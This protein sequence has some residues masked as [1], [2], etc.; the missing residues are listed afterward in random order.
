MV[1]AFLKSL[2]VLVSGML[3]IGCAVKK[4]QTILPE[5][6]PV[7]IQ[8]GKNEQKVDNF[9][10]ILD[11]SGTMN[12]TYN[13]QTKFQ[14]ASEVLKRMN[15]TIP[16]LKLTTGLRT[17][18]QGFSDTTKLQYGMTNYT[19]EGLE[20]AINSVNKGGATPLGLAINETGK[21]LENTQGN[22]AVII[23]SDGKETDGTSVKS[24]QSLKDK[25]RDRLC[26]YT[27]LVGDDLGGKALM[28]KIAKTGECGFSVN[29]DEI[30]SSGDIAGFV[31]K[32]F[33][34][35]AVAVAKPLDSDGDG[36]YDDSDRCPNTPAGVKVDA[37]GCPLDTDGDGVYDYMDKCPGTPT[38]VAVDSSGC[39]LDSDGDG[40]YDYLDKCPNTPR[41]VQVDAKGCPVDSDEDGVYDYMDKCPDTPKSAVVD[42][43]GCWV[44]KGVLFDTAK[45]DI[46]PQSY[47][48]LDALVDVLKENPFLRLE[49][50]GHTDNR[51]SAIFNKALSDGRAKAVMDYIVKMGID[52]NRLT[53]VGYG[54]TM[55]AAT[56]D[57]V[58][59]RAQNRRVELKPIK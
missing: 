56:N 37:N 41:G 12:E 43:R 50:Q 10:T 18:G 51:G 17:I 59:G 34:R 27:V 46:K 31:E 47:Q 9:L 32:V 25:Y 35:K 48:N 39:P 2:F 22:T 54:F 5:F 13:G 30:Y 19:K 33:L 44:L 1:K 28:D 20:G 49:I 3:M 29:A 15:Q 26:L 58:E 11:A 8:A 21:D 52:P 23:V 6:K 16:D 55:P 38:G 14:I 40:V 42:Q 36:V 53:A 7:L 24:A 57:S 4:P 45:S